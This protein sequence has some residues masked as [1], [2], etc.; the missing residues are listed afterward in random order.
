MITVHHLNNSR[1]HRII[2]LLE[3]LEVAYEIKS[4]QRKPNLQAPSTLKAIHPLGVA[5]IITDDNLTLTES[6]AIIEYILNKYGDNQLKPA[7][8]TPDGVQYY[9]WLHFAEGSFMPMLLLQLVFENVYQHLPFLIKP[10]FKAIKTRVNH[11][12][13]SPR[14]VLQLK[15]I[16]SILQ[17]KEWLAGPSFTAADIQ[18]AIPLLWAMESGS[19]KE[20]AK[21]DAYLERIKAR[22]AFVR[23]LE[24]GGDIS[25]PKISAS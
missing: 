10:I 25:R 5:P 15:Y 1:S 13:M 24:K 6:G 12:L 22:A 4:Y 21:I 23:A 19:Y 3:E 16:E 9:F 14:I 20:F 17:K 11:H 8:N 18:M 2:W 7:F